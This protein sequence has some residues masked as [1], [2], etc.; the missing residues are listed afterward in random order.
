VCV[1]RSRQGT[2]TVKVAEI[3]TTNSTFKCLVLNEILLLK[4]VS[5]F[6]MTLYFENSVPA[7]PDSLEFSRFHFRKNI[8]KPVGIRHLF[9]NRPRGLHFVDNY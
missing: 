1:W 9:Y 8:Y 5:P 4:L 3:V 2:N 7:L 6:S